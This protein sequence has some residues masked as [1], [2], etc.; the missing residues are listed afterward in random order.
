MEND[1]QDKTVIED[2]HKAIRVVENWPKDGITFRDFT[3]V[4]SDC[5]L[6][7]RIL[8]HLAKNLEKTEFDAIA[9]LETRG[10]LFGLLLSQKLKKPFIVVRKAGK[11]PPPTHKIKYNLE[12]GSAEFEVV[13]GAIKKGW[14]VIVHDD[15]LATGGSALAAGQLVVDSGATV[16]GYQF[17][18]TLKGLNG[19]K[20]IESKIPAPVFTLLE[21]D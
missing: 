17:L 5:D 19:T 16:A 12:Y 8:N 7:E 15:L 9:G 4:F 20:N 11:L 21:Y 18:I 14:K 10:Y 13:E 2:F 3:P 1:N 6:T